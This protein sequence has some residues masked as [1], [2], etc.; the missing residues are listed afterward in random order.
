MSRLK[1]GDGPPMYDL[2]VDHGVLYL[3]EMGVPWNGL[4]SVDEQATGEVDTDHYFDGNRIHISQETGDFEAIVSAYT[5]PDVFGEYNGYSERE[6]YRRFGFSYRT[7][8]GAD[9]YK[10]H[11]VY[12]VL[13]RN[14][15]RAWSTLRAVVDPSLFNWSIHASAEPVPGASPAGRL[16]LEAPRDP[17]VL[18]ELE[19][20][21]YGTET[22]DPRLPGPAEIVELYEAA[23]L[24]RITYNAD[25]TYTASGPDDMVRLLGDG[26]FEINAPTVVPIGDGKF[27]I[28]SY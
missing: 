11:I 2:G 8:H 15:T 4:V 19:D 22:S 3:D 21:L 5:Y 23:T 12:K 9:S 18:Q 24:L 16:T 10:L 26:R 27:A 14:D 17:S 28:S 1:W 13:V 6:E 7:Q 25:G 20:I